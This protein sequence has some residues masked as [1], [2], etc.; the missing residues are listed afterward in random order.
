MPSWNNFFIE[1]GKKR[2]LFEGQKVFSTK[3]PIG[4]T[5][6]TGPPFY[7]VIRREAR[8]GLA[9]CRAKAVP[10]FLSH[11]KTLGVGPVP[12]IEPATSRSAVKSSTNW[13]NPAVVIPVGGRLWELLAKK[14]GLWQ[15][16][17]DLGEVLCSAV[18]VETRVCGVSSVSRAHKTSLRSILFCICQKH[19]LETRRDLGRV[20]FH[21]DFWDCY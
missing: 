2:T 7:L 3:V 14:L 8:E 21:K 10:S 1:G 4:Y 5:I 13:A 6:L 17:N 9:I 11:F 18:L 16:N 15:C 20:N 19:D 12:G